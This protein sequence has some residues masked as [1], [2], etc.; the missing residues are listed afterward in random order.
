MT[1]SSCGTVPLE[2]PQEVEGQENEGG[3]VSMHPIDRQ[4]TGGSSLVVPSTPAGERENFQM[5]FQFQSIRNLP[6]SIR[7][8]LE[9]KWSRGS[10]QSGKTLS[11]PC[12]G[13]ECL[14]WSEPQS[15][16]FCVSLKK[17]KGKN[18][19]DWE[20]RTLSLTLR[21][22]KKGWGM[23][24]EIGRVKLQLADYIGDQ[25]K[26]YDKELSSCVSP[27][28]ILEIVVSAELA[29]PSLRVYDES[30]ATNLSEDDLDGKT[31][32]TISLADLSEMGDS[33]SSGDMTKKY[34]MLR[35]RAFALRDALIKWQNYANKLKDNNQSLNEKLKV[36]N[37]EKEEA[38]AM[39]TTLE[40]KL[41][42]TE[43]A[44]REITNELSK[45]QDISRKEREEREREER[46]KEGERKES[47]MEE[48]LKGQLK[49]KEKQIQLLERTLSEKDDE[50]ASLTA[51][52]NKSLKTRSGSGPN[53]SF[54]TSVVALLLLVLVAM[55]YTSFTRSE[56]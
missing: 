28:P 13:E 17:K 51:S 10:K 33:H 29:R 24:K 45:Y 49:E 54:M 15:A 50:L 22:V 23:T 9:L 39:V 43:E 5:C 46:E 31:W 2:V 26:V 18:C 37:I 42:G 3:A 12:T 44:K 19:T 41:K 20:S 30:E 14:K 38:M 6:K 11:L 8:E 27:S 56:A 21:Q 53:F 32:D 40:T 48:L 4:A 55:V 25:G 47:E 16:V 52:L 34:R 1:D 35:Q 7:G 36:R